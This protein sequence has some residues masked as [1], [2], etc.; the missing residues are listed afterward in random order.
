MRKTDVVPPAVSNRSFPGPTAVDRG[1][2]A[3]SRRKCDP[4]SWS[5]DCTSRHSAMTNSE[6][7]FRRRAS[8]HCSTNRVRY[9]CHEGSNR[10][11]FCPNTQISAVLYSL[12][13]KISSIQL[14]SKF[15]QRYAEMIPHKQD[16]IK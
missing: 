11:K 3:L 12:T 4:F 2:V 1:I 15:A 14:C 10:F 16:T 13:L 6:T 5:A 9:F 8:L 7:K